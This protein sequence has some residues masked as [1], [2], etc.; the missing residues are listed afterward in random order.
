MR[1]RE[2]LMKDLYS[3]SRGEE[4]FRE[5]YEKCAA[6]YLKI[7]DRVGLGALTYRTVAAGGSFTSGFTDEFQTLSTA[8]E[9]IIYVDK[10][11][12]IAVNKEVYTDENLRK[13]GLKKEDLVE[14]KSIEVG[15]IFPLGTKYSSALGL[16]FIDKDGVKSPV[17]MGSYG[18]GLGRVMGTIVETLSDEKGIVWPEAIA[19]F[20]V[21]LIS[22]GEKGS[23]S[24]VYAEKIY[25]E[26]QQK[27]I[28][29]LFD[30]RP[31]RAGEKFA[32]S[33]LIG[34]PI[35]VV[36]SDKT[37]EKNGLEVK[38]RT[39]ETATIFTETDFFALF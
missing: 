11:K 29:V 26:L 2:F 37:L 32:D 23:A 27:G 28:E 20:K 9:D 31:T 6:A 10:K 13:L 5:F 38:R 1:A 16:V 12:K 35:R 18:I 33:E 21:H 17:V 7:F 30:D 8:G 34:I 3:F 19:P 36:V 24:F 14:E 4:E 15:N 22:L 39:E 25:T